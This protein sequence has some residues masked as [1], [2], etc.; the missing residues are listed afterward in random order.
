MWQQWNVT[1]YAGGTNLGKISLT[2]LPIHYLI[3][4]ATFDSDKTKILR[5]LSPM[6]SSQMWTQRFTATYPSW[7]EPICES[8]IS[9]LLIHTRIEPNVCMYNSSRQHM[10]IKIIH[11]TSIIQAYHHHSTHVNYPSIA[12]HHIPTTKSLHV[13]YTYHHI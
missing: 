12:H 6:G 13:S 1:K 4:Q 11:K 9:P 2:P 7:I 5:Y 10:Q 3:I 8:N